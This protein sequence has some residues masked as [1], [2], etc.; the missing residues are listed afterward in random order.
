MKVKNIYHSFHGNENVERQRSVFSQRCLSS[1][2]NGISTRVN[3][4]ISQTSH[5]RLRHRR[6]VGFRLQ[7]G[8]INVL[9]GKWCRHV[10]R[11]SS[12][13]HLAREHR[14]TSRT[15]TTLALHCNNTEHGTWRQTAHVT[16]QQLLRNSFRVRTEIWLWLFSTLPGQ[17]YFVYQTFQ[18][19]L[20]IFMW[21]KE[22]QNWL[23]N[24][25]ILYTTYSTIQNIEW[26]SNFWTLNFRCFGHEL[27]E[28]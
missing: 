5:L 22:L 9:P 27:Q 12:G 17:Y 11:V 1:T 24:A 28:N 26:D 16:E 21:T 10:W 23:L 2:C 19:I 7:R 6:T 3:P 15:V 4:S 25:E 18:G 8:G 13:R 14:A 20:F